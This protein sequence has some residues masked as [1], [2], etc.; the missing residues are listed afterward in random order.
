MTD[1][2]CPWCGKKNRTVE[3]LIDGDEADDGSVI[4][5]FGC[6]AWGVLEAGS[7]RKATEAEVRKGLSDPEIVRAV[8]TFSRLKKEV[9]IP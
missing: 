6:E 3:S 8:A 4:I 9:F 2:T 1:F 5:C 7:L